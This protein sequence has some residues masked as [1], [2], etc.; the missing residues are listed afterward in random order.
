MLLGGFASKGNCFYTV[1]GCRTFRKTSG[2]LVPYLL[3][4]GGRHVQ[5]LLLSP[6]CSTS[7]NCLFV[8]MSFLLTD[9]AFTTVC[10]CCRLITHLKTV[11]LFPCPFCQ[12]ITRS[13]TMLLLPPANSTSINCLFVSMSFL[14]TDDMFK[15]ACRYCRLIAHP[16]TVSLFL[17]TCTSNFCL[18]MWM[19]V[20]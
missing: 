9:D 6:V 8:S 4:T 16:K 1:V 11:S 15:I 3:P 10:R 20:S 13:N 14:P 12:L 19:M 18:S 7:E 2:G 17:C 5:I